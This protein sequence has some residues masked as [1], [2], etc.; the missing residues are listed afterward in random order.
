M[1][2]VSILG[3]WEGKEAA[4]A[5][6]LGADNKHELYYISTVTVYRGPR[7]GENGK[8]FR[9]AAL[10]VPL[11]PV[12]EI[13]EAVCGLSVGH[14]SRIVQ[15]RIRPQLQQIISICTAFGKRSIVFDGTNVEAAFSRG[16]SVRLPHNP[17]RHPAPP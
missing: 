14:Q 2:I 17:T 13:T 9:V 6:A 10:L 5:N 7:R 11:L 12:E 16:K 1:D 4:K 8:H 15:G 3:K